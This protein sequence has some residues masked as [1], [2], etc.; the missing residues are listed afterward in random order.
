ML[1]IEKNKIY[2]L[3]KMTIF[4]KIYNFNNKMKNNKI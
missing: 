2:I 1:N 4:M 3:N